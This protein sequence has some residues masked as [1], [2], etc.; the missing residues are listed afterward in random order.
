[1]LTPYALPNS[2]YADLTSAQN[3]RRYRLFIGG[4][5]PR[6]KAESAHDVIIVVDGN[7]LFPIVTEHLRLLEIFRPSVSPPLVVGV[8]YPSD[9]DGL[10]LAYRNQDMALS[11]ATTIV[12]LFLRFVR[13]G[14]LKWVERQ[15][16]ISVA[17]SYLVGHSWGGSLEHL[18]FPSVAASVSLLSESIE[19]NSA[20]SPRV[21][22]ELFEGENHTS[23][24]T[25]AMAKGVQF[26]L[27]R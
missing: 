11:G 3:Q 19:E 9:D 26:L 16:H 13:E 17:N 10:I 7:W 5:D 6:K 27:G 23:V 8:G 4:Y 21:R 15:L 12:E 25:H 18:E 24:V 20:S 2:H 22:C 1:M 14:V